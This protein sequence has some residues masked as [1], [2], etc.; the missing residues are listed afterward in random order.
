MSTTI[1][2]VEDPKQLER[3][4]AT[5]QPCCF[6]T[7]KEVCD[8]FQHLFAS[9]RNVYRKSVTSFIRKAIPGEE[10]VTSLNGVHETSRTVP[11]DDKDYWVVCAR[12]AGEL[13]VLS[14]EEFRE[15]YDLS[16]AKP[17]RIVEENTSCESPSNNN[18]PTTAT[19]N[20]QQYYDLY[21]LQQQG[22]LEYASLRKIV[23]HEVTHE[24]MEFFMGRNNN[25]NNSSQ[26]CPTATATTTESS[27]SSIS[28]TENML[29]G[30]YFMAPWGE[31]MRVEAGDYLSMTYPLN[32]HQHEICRIETSA[33]GKSYTLLSP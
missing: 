9:S 15:N 13:Y 5:S 28:R 26:D 1:S 6:R 30:V 3:S 8:H 11:D 16:S 21:Q 14:D 24:D 27:S 31:P 29:W 23:A 10:I 4:E 32:D 22:Y 20:G 17:I 18:D 19:S 25:N 2:A 12:A 33:F 7:Q